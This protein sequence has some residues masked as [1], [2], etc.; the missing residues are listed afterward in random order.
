MTVC[1]SLAGASKRAGSYEIGQV[2]RSPLFGALWRTRY[3][4]DGKMLFGGG[5]NLS[6]PVACHDGMFDQ[7][8]RTLALRIPPSGG[9]CVPSA[10]LSSAEIN[11]CSIRV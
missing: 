10:Y 11:T 6:L 8:H 7:P 1:H 5:Q 4:V 3:H 9:L 2:F